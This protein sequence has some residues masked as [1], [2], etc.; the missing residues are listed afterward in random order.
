MEPYAH[1][2]PD[3]QKPQQCLRLWVTSWRK[4]SALT[5][6]K[7]QVTFP[8]IALQEHTANS[9]AIPPSHH[10][11]TTHHFNT[12]MR[13][14]IAV[15]WSNLYSIRGPEP[16]AQLRRVPLPGSAV[17]VQLCPLLSSPDIQAF[18]CASYFMRALKALNLQRRRV[19]SGS[20]LR[21]HLSSFSC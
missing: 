4:S 13:D 16:P 2:C 20:F 21:K 10:L 7:E 9:A 15:M 18:N 17:C 12:V 11:V 1:S 8:L 3:C 6:L 19:V 14:S 5:I